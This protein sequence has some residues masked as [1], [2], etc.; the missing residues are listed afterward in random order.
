MIF[1]LKFIDEIK[2]SEVTNDF[3]YRLERTDS[4]R[5]GIFSLISFKQ[6]VETINKQEDKQ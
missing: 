4:L 1:A 6:L 3:D 5:S 2:L